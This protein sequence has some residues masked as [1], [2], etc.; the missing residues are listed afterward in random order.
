MVCS[1][2]ADE[3]A[4]RMDRGE[5]R[6]ADP[7]RAATHLVGLLEAGPLQW[8]MYGALKTVGEDERASTVREAVDVFLRAYRC[9]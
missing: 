2:L 1:K 4:S 8:H 6:R 9:D 5:M 7:W 3:F